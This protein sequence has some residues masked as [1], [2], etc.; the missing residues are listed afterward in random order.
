ML[1]AAEPALVEGLLLLSYPLHPPGRPAQLRTAHF[2][3]LQTPVLFVSGTRDAFGSTEELQAAIKLI[4][5]R[6]RLLPIEGAAHGLMQK[7][8]RAELPGKIVAEFQEFFLR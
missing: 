1:V 8:N 3:H 6:S 5:A 2:S 7:S 4:P